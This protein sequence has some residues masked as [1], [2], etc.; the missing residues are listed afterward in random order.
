MLKNHNGGF[1]VSSFPRYINIVS[2]IGDSKQRILLCGRA[3]A[4]CPLYVVYCARDGSNA[5]DIIYVD[6]GFI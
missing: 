3:T 2:Y 5:Y 6:H 1:I 4:Y